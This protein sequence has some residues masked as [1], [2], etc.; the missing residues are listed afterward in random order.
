[1]T[2]GRIIAYIAA[3]ILIFFGFL[4]V[5]GAF[6]PQ[7]SPGW[8]P[9]GLISL[10]SGFVLIWLAGRRKAG[11]EKQEIVQRIE[12]SGDV[13]LEKMTCRSCGGALS[14]ENVKVVAGA[15]VVHCPF[16]GTSYHLEEEPKW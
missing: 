2:A 16:C 10:G 12:L 7:G 4:F 13:S 6:S 14:P 11:A 8:I 5:Y 15:A 1:M 3:A 9:V